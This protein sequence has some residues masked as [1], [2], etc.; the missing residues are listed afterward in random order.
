MFMTD[1]RELL[2]DSESVVLNAIVN[3]IDEHR[4]P[5]TIRDLCELTGFTSTCTI[6]LKLKALR[7]KGCIEYADN[8]MRTIVVCRETEKRGVKG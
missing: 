3:F 6:H 1:V 8:K 4:I 2:N 7:E 5:P